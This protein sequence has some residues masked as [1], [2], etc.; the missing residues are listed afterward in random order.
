M[1]AEPEATGPLK[2]LRMIELGV[3]LAG[4]FCGQL[5]GDYGCEVIKIEPPGQHDP[6]RDWGQFKPEGQSLW[7]PIVAR[8]K[9]CATLNLRTKEGQE[10][11]KALVAKSD[12]LL[13]NFRPGTME[14]WGLGWEELKKINPGLIMIRVSGLCQRGRSDGRLALCDGRAGPAALAR[15]HLHRRQSGGHLRHRRRARRAGTSP[16]H[17]RR[18][19]DRQLHL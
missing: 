19:G 17:R 10:A 4:P 12:F 8:N 6:L 13:E 11:L 14:K 9:K 7:F 2:G 18:P 5:M 15:G 16:P 1:S 3:L